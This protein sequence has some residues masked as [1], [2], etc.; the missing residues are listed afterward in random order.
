MQQLAGVPLHTYAI[1]QLL[2]YV[3]LLFLQKLILHVTQHIASHNT[4]VE[5]LAV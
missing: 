1:G 2:E 3:E 4:Y 5:H